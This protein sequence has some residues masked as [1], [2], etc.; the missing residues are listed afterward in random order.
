[1]V[2]HLNFPANNDDLKANVTNWRW[3]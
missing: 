2:F 1:V 3:S